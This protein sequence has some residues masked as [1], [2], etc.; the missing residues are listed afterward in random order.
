MADNKDY[1]Y[2]YEDEVFRVN[3]KGTLQFGMVIE[4]AEFNSDAESSDEEQPVGAGQVR[5]AWY[6]KGTEEVVSEKNVHLADR[7]LMPGD[8]VRRLVKGKK[9]QMGYCKNVKVFSSVQIIGTSQVVF[10]VGSEELV[11]LEQF[12]SEILICLDGWVGMVRNVQSNLSL[13]FSDGSKVVVTDDLAEELDDIRDK[14]DPECE[15]KRYD[16][17]PG[18]VLFGAIRNLESGSWSECSP[19]ILAV[20]KQK[21]HKAFKVTVEDIEFAQL[22]VSWMCKAFSSSAEETKAQPKYKVE[23]EDL[24][25][26]KM[27]NVFEPCTLQIGDRNFYLMKENDI[28]LTKSDWK[29]LLKDQLLKDRKVKTK[30]KSCKVGRS[31]KL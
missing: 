29:K 27:L 11:P 18:Q 25:R 17:Y 10:G 21:P 14:R 12:K 3:R 6:P 2:F 16:F 22:G 7:S 23:G 9:T 5:V 28:V 31:G 1:K 26:V 20:R 15:F 4:N 30:K 13:R 24:K 8:I 19:E